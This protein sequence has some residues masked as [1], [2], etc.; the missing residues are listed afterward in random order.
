MAEYEFQFSVLRSAVSGKEALCR[1]LKAAARDMEACARSLEAGPSFGSVP[2]SLAAAAASLQQ[3]SRRLEIW[4]SSLEE[5]SG[6]WQQ[7]EREILSAA[8]PRRRFAPPGSPLPAGPAAQDREQDEDLGRKEP[9]AAAISGA[10]AVSNAAAVSGAAARLRAAVEPEGSVKT[11]SADPDAAEES[12]AV[13]D[14]KDGSV[15]DELC[16]QISSGTGQRPYSPPVFSTLDP[17]KKS[18]YIAAVAAALYKQ[19]PSLSLSGSSRIE[20]PLGNGT[21]AYSSLS[22]TGTNKKSNHVKLSQAV[23]RNTGLLRENIS[24]SSDGSSVS[25]SKDGAS[26]TLRTES[27]TWKVDPTSLSR[28]A[29]VKLD[30]QTSLS[31]TEKVNAQGYA[32]FEKTVTSSVDGVSVS[33]S[34]GVKMTEPKRPDGTPTPV[35]APGVRAAI[36][37]RERMQAVSRLLGAALAGSPAGAAIPVPVP[38]G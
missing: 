21:S 26:V 17:L 2:G 6:I 37:Q 30:Q 1:I 12:A 32:S 31:F 22:V 25:F 15:S 19:F 38:A 35:L 20:V 33:A 24:I 4:L 27:G 16:A 13:P 7:A 9:G 8:P 28:T 3:Q 14:N 5:I 10:A 18:A 23:D 11:R 29:R 36:A 34:A